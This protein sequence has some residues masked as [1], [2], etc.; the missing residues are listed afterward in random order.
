MDFDRVDLP[1]Q[2][3]RS[4][5]TIHIPRTATAVYSG[6]RQMASKGVTQECSSTYGERH[7]EAAMA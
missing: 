2:T 1:P 5:T 4:H 7:G 6:E 3:A